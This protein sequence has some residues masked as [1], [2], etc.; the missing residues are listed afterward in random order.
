VLEFSSQLSKEPSKVS[1][2]E[3]TRN[4]EHVV[5]DGGSSDGTLEILERYR[6][7]LHWL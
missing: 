5:K 3:I 4:I 2:R 7:R 1:W 6:D